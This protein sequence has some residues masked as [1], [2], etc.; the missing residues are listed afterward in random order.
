LL[1]FLNFEGGHFA[2]LEEPEALWNDIEAFVK[3]IT[4]DNVELI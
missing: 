1:T 2:A 4:E 3:Q